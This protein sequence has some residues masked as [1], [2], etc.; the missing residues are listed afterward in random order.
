MSDRIIMSK[1]N[2]VRTL[3]SCRK[4]KIVGFVIGSFDILH[5]GH[6]DLLRKAKEQCDILVVGVDSDLSIKLSKGENRPMN[7]LAERMAMLD[8][9]RSVDFIYP[10]GQSV[11]FNSVEHVQA[12]FEIIQSIRADYVFT[13]LPRDNSIALKKQYAAEHGIEYNLI[14]TGIDKHISTTMIFNHG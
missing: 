7:A 1:E 11:R 12:Y 8:E 14:N 13:F 5:I 10:M 6:V 2:L 3:E 9:L 4:G